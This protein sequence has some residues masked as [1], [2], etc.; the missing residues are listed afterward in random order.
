M[1]TQ[2]ALLMLQPS[3]SADRVFERQRVTGPDATCVS[4]DGGF[5][6]HQ[7]AIAIIVMAHLNQLA[8]HRDARDHVAQNT[9]IH[10]EP[11]ALDLDGR[12]V[13]GVDNLA[14]IGLEANDLGSERDE[15]NHS[16]TS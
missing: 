13:H 16:I 2:A 3:R 7:V 5:V 10:V 9:V 1:K 11:R 12:V 4:L 14:T 6:L 8:T 15:A